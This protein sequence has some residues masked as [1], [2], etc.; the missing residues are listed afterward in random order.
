MICAD[1]I[2]CDLVYPGHWHIPIASLNS[3][4]A[5]RTITLMAPSKTFNIAGLT[6]FVCG[7]PESQS[8]GRQFSR[9]AM[10]LV[11]GVNVLGPGRG[12][13]GIRGRTGVA[14]PAPGLPGRQPDLLYPHMSTSSMPGVQ[15]IHPE[16]TYLAWL[17]CREARIGENAGDFFLKNARVALNDGERVWQGGEGFVR[18]ELWLPAFDAGRSTG[19]AAERTGKS[20]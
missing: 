16:G 13:G 2:H 10:G 8:C 12:A 6:L 1:E 20:D 14:R 17:D 11:H 5:Q 4:I 9:G 7:D 18:L 3:E 15:M 19:A